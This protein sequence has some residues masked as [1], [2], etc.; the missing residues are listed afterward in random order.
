M[1]ISHIQI[2]H[3]TC[4]PK[5]ANDLLLFFE[6]FLRRKNSIKMKIISECYIIFFFNRMTH[7][8]LIFQI[9]FPVFN[10]VGVSGVIV[11]PFSMI[12]YQK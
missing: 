9:K 12:L 6:K 4:A 5:N 1:S 8:G 2:S 11:R 10:F 7:C 3:E